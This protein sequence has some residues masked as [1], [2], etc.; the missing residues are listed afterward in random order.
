[1]EKAVQRQLNLVQ[2][3]ERSSEIDDESEDQERA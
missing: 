2:L 1:V 3:E